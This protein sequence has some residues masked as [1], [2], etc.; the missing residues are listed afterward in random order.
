MKG[1]FIT[2]EGIEGSGKSTQIL[3]LANYLK[4]RNQPVT[5]TREPGGTAIGDQ[6]R[7]IL[8]DPGNTMLV[9][10][11]ELLLYAASRA[12][13]LEE[14][15][16]PELAAGST[17]LCDRFSD[18]TI[19]YQGYGRGLDLETIRS[20]DRIVT[21]GMTPDLTI[22]L[23]IDTAQGL[24][25]ARGRNSSRGLETE[26]RFENEEIS[27]HERV[28]RGYRALADAAPD[29]YRLMDASPRPDEI[30]NRIRAIVDATLE[31]REQRP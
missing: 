31:R 5:L 2:F 12:Q 30:Q 20:L 26:A 17:V 22:L 18:A 9:P 11:A 15:I 7:R 16:L 19:A 3:L 28:R 24:S 25:R 29:R 21:K 14:L 23:D 1:L 8:L 6:V 10:A 27:F 4:A 13:H